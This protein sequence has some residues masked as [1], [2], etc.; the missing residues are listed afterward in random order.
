[1]LRTSCVGGYADQGGGDGAPH[2]AELPL[3]EVV[4]VK[5]GCVT[6]RVTPVGRT[7]ANGCR[8][9]AAA[10]LVTL[11]ACFFS[12]IHRQNLCRRP[13]HGFQIRRPSTGTMDSFL[14]VLSSAA[15]VGEYTKIYLRTALRFSDFSLP[16]PISKTPRETR[17]VPLRRQAA[18]SFQPLPGVSNKLLCP[19]WKN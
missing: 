17:D 18:D 4:D 2:A 9:D 19:A 5:S 8:D 14:D 3:R 1:M 6:G 16:H 15:E 10:A 11:L 12:F 7:S 13:H